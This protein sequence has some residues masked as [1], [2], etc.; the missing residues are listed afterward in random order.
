MIVAASAV[1]GTGFLFAGL[2]TEWSAWYLP[3]IF[4]VAIAG[5]S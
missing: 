3:V 5:G 2:A 1:Y 4:A